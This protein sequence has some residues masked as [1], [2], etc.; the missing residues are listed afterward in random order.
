MSQKTKKNYKELK[1]KKKTLDK[2]KCSQHE[3]TQ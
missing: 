1:L 2:P 3:P